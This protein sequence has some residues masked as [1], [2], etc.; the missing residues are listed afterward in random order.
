MDGD[1]SAQ[2]LPT[3]A[4][5]DAVTREI[6]HRIKKQLILPYLDLKVR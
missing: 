4:S 3:T 2:T 6:W 1:E 5:D